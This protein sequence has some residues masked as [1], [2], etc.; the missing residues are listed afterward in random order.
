MPLICTDKPKVKELSLTSNQAKTMVANFKFFLTSQKIMLKIDD[1]NPRFVKQVE[2][3][4]QELY[5][6]M[7]LDVI[8]NSIFII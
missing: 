7:G 6:N 2:N 1:L 5:L 4:V 3:T 8:M